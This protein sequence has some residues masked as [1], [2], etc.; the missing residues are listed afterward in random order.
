[1]Y[2][3]SQ[4]WEVVGCGDVA[5]SGSVSLASVKLLVETPVLPN[6]RK[7]KQKTALNFLCEEDMS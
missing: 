2:Q 4:L 1:M 7:N 6:K 3:S 5:L